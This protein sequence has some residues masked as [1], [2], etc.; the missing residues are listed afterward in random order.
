MKLPKI[1]HS[2]LKKIAKR[3]T[4]KRTKLMI[5][6][7][8]IISFSSALMIRLAP[9]K[10]GF[11]LNEFDPYYDYYAANF[12]VNNAEKHGLGVILSDDPNVN[13]FLWHDYRTWYPEGRDV[14][15]TSQAGL[16]LAGAALYLFFKY[17][18]GIDISLYDF[19]VL[20][21]VFFGALTV[22][23]IFLLTR[24]IFN[25]GAGLLSSLIV[26]FSLPLIQRGNLGW[27]KSEPLALFL[28][29]LS[30]YFFFSIF[31]SNVKRVGILWRAILAGLL[32]G[33]ANASWGGVQYFN[34]VMGLVFLISPFLDV[35]LKRVIYSGSIF[36]ASNLLLSSAFPR[37]GP[38]IILSS[39]IILFAGLAFAMLGHYIK[40]VTGP[41][42]HKK[43]LIISLVAFA[44]LGLF[45]MSIDLLPGVSGRYLTAIFPFQRTTDPLVESVAE[46]Q[47]TSGV[48][49]FTSFWTLIFLGV[50][51]AFIMLKKRTIFSA[52]ALILGITS[53]YVA[54]SFSRLMV[55]ASIAFSILA[56]IGFSELSSSLLKPTVPTITKK[57]VKAYALRPEVKVFSAIFIIALLAS[58]NYYWLPRYDSPVS[59]VIS[60]LQYDPGY[61]VTDWLEALTWIRENTPENAV[62]IAWWDYGYWITVMGNRTSVADNATINSTRI[63]QIGRLF[64]S[65]E[66][67]AKEIIDQ[68]RWDS[69]IGEYRPA[70]I[71]VL[72]SATRYQDYVLIGGRPPYILNL[73][74][75]EG[76]INWFAAIPRLNV[77]QFIGEDD[78]PTEYFWKNTLLGKMLPMDYD[79]ATSENYKTQLGIPATFP[80]QIGKYTIKY[81]QN[82]TGPLRLAF[83]SSFK[84]YAQVLIYEVV[85]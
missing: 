22:F 78:L 58:A 14:A 21:P 16:H 41:K 38:S 1:R 70:Y 10:F 51:G 17:F 83:A 13:Y 61:P 64:L 35:D 74:G 37:P 73:G 49:F 68:L 77:S 46:H 81:P 71:A 55:Y 60:G 53:I 69:C 36:V 26:A 7:V 6:L 39:G 76:K 28:T 56:G 31:S 29:V 57:K 72:F 12:I 9:A 59:I 45:I 27:F 52:Y 11:Y 20:F 18:F 47:T 75:D 67:K 85:E 50:F 42:D 4:I 30:F 62:I 19:L 65:N 40:S 63:Q 33:Y 44:L 2:A 84:S 54:S 15:A 3:P 23:A 8:L 24:K 5:M 32:L 79:K 82:S 80:A 25:T 66:T 48:Y 34:G 43:N